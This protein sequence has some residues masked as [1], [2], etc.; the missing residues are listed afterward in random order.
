M[1]N[2]AEG[3]NSM[4]WHFATEHGIIGVLGCKNDESG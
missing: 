3:F 4:R 1:R 2:S